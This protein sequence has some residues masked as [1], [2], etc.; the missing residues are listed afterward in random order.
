MNQDAKTF[1]HHSLQDAKSIRTILRA[2]TTGLG[3]GTVI[4][5]DDDQEP[6]ELVPDGLM[7]L[8]VTASQDMGHNKL[9]IQVQ[10]HGD[11]DG[12][13]QSRLSVATK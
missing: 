1:F 6:V 4:L 12:L 11:P 8:T 5:S 3:K 13:K 10:W 2:I 7:E 9:S